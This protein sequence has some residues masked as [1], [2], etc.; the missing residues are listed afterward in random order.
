MILTELQEIHVCVTMF[1][2]SD[3]LCAHYRT[4]YLDHHIIWISIGVHGFLPTIPQ[5]N[6]SHF[7]DENDFA[8]CQLSEMMQHADD[9]FSV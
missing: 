9:K 5:C 3:G 2:A 4:T 8:D 6:A 7:I 1:K